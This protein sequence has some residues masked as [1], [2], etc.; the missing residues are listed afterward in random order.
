MNDS[1]VIRLSA[2]QLGSM[3]SGSGRIPRC[4][5]PEVRSP[6]TPIPGADAELE[7]FRGE[8]VYYLAKKLR[9][10]PNVVMTRLG[11]WDLGPTVAGRWRLPGKPSKLR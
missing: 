4:D 10:P 6:P 2:T 5:E 3:T 7:A 1:F 8:L 9:V 11:D